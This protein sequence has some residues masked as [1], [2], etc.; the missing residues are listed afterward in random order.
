MKKLLLS[1]GTEIKLGEKVNISQ[2]T[3][4]KSYT[5]TGILTEEL[6]KTLIELG[7]LKEVEYPDE[8]NKVGIKDVKDAQPAISKLGY[9]L[10]QVALSEG[11]SDKEAWKLFHDACE[12]CAGI[13]LNILL[14]DI[15]KE[16]D[17]RYA[18]HVK[19][20]EKAFILNGT[21]I[22]IVTVLTPRFVYKL[23]PMFRTVADAKVA[24]DMLKPYVLKVV[25]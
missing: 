3:P 17:K 2:K 20:A 21:F 9:Y 22:R 13:A 25:G 10:H 14:W 8:N 4:N 19:T 7:E 16:M 18:S 15:A 1:N 6:V 12:D 24:M 11:I 23:I 5:I